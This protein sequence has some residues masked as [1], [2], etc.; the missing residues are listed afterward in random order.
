MCVCGRVSHVLTETVVPVSHSLVPVAVHGVQIGHES[1]LW[2]RSLG[3]QRLS[4]SR[5]EH[6]FFSARVSVVRDDLA[7]GAYTFA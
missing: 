7:V 5:C 2:L 1:S 3:I 4:E 6:V